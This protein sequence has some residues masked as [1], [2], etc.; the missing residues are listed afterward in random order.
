[1]QKDSIDD[2][3]LSLKD[4]NLIEYFS[5]TAQLPDPDQESLI[6]LAQFP[7]VIFISDNRICYKKEILHLNLW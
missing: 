1:M 6:K 5:E 2:I 7:V 4:S 3:L